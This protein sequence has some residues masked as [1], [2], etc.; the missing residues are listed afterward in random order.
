MKKILMTGATGFL[1]SRLAEALVHQGYD[2]TVLVRPASVLTKIGHLEPRLHVIR[3]VNPEDAFD[4]KGPFQAVIHTATCYGRDGDALDV[5]DANLVLPLKLLC[6]MRQHGGGAFFNTDSFFTKSD[7]VHDYLPD[8][9]ITK[10]AFREMGWN[11]A[12]KNNLQF[13]NLTLEHLYGRGDGEGKFITMLVRQLTTSAPE[14][15]L[16]SG[17]QMRDFI[18]VDDAIQAYLRLLD[19]VD[20]LPGCT[21]W[22]IGTGQPV[23]IQ[24]FAEQA[25]SLAQSDTILNFGAL[26]DRTQ[27]IQCSYADNSRLFALGWAPQYDITAGLQAILS[28]FQPQRADT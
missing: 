17:R 14:I 16:T 2:V 28:E 15:D 20:R 18:Y 3:T 23:S 27:E 21:Q 10:K 11:Y 7:L 13:L 9:T 26:P 1:G 6:L 4:A 24:A 22:G 25:K 12:R 19:H 8:Y 5:V